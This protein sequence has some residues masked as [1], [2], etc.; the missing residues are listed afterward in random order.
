MLVLTSTGGEGIPTLG[1]S[2]QYNI[3]N[4]KALVLMS[5]FSLVPL[6]KPSG[7]DTGLDRSYFYIFE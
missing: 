6:K 2:H 4:F 7:S 5:G 1:L 3:I